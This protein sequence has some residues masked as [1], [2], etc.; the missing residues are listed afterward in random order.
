MVKY[1]LFNILY[2]RYHAPPVPFLLY[3]QIYADFIIVIDNYQNNYIID[4]FSIQY[5]TDTLVGVLL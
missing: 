4:I 5:L 1:L 3:I 2:T